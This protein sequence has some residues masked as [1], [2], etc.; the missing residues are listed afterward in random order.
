M[1]EIFTIGH[2]N[3]SLEKFIFLL[4]SN[5][6]SA[7]VDIRSSPFCS[8]ARHFNGEAIKAALKERGIKYLFLGDALGGKPKE[9]E[10][11]DETGM[12][13]YG[14]IAGTQKFQE[15]IK[16][17][18]N[19]IS[20]HKVALL[21][22]EENPENCHRR[23][24]VGRVLQ[25]KGVNIIHIRGEGSTQTEGELADE[26]KK[27]SDTRQIGL[28]KEEGDKDWKSTLSVSPRKAQASFS[29]LSKTQK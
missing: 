9:A 24:L 21:C 15:G 23:L 20:K 29:K 26:I 17:L 13:L 2:S 8:Y 25:E 1:T 4:C 7:V 18:L 27:R 22:S 16:R 12:A 14:K 11:Y 28:F 6:I 3:H 19:G 10:F 5:A